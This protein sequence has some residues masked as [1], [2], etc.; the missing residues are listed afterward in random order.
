MQKPLCTDTAARNRSA[1]RR[2]PA[3]PQPPAVDQAVLDALPAHVAVLDQSGTIVAVNRAWRE[4]SRSGMADESETCEG[5]NYPAVCEAVQGTERT[6]AVT[7]AHSLRKTL[8]GELNGFEW[9]YR[10]N[11]CDDE[12]WFLLRAT[13]I[14][15]GDRRRVVVEHEDITRFRKLE[16]ELRSTAEHHRLL[17]EN[18]KDV[19][20]VLDT[21][22]GYFRYVSPSITGL[23]GYTVAETLSQ[24]VDAVMMPDARAGLKAALSQRVAAFHD[25]TE[26]PG[27]YYTDIVEQPRK[28]GS[29]VW[30]EAVSRLRL[31]GE[32]GHV[33]LHGVTRDIT[34]RRAAEAALRESAQFL[35]QGEEIAGIGGW[36]ASPK[37]DHLYWTEGVYRIIEAPRDYR[38]GLDEG[39]KFYTPEYIPVLKQ[40]LHETLEHGTPFK[41]EAEIVTATGRHVWGEVRGLARLDELGERYV[42]GT[43]LDITDR[44]RDEDHRLR[45]AAAIEQATESVV[46]TDAAGKILYVNP[47]FEAT[48]GWRQDEILGSGLSFL[49]SGRHDG[50]FFDHVWATVRG[51]QS[52]RG[53]ITSRRRNGTLYTED[54]AISPVRNRKG[55]VTSFAFVT[56]DITEELAREAHLQQAQKIESGG[57][58]AGGVA[59]DLNNLLS[60]ILGY[61]ELLLDEI[62]TGDSRREFVEEIHYAGLRARN[63]VRQLLAFGRKQTL[64]VKGLDLNSVITHFRKLLRRTIRE[65]IELETHLSASIAPILADVGQIEQVIMN[66]VINAQDAIP[67]AGR[68]VLTTSDAVVD[69]EFAA[70]HQGIKPGRFVLLRISDTG[71]GMDA[72]TLRMIFEPFFTTKEA[73][74]GTGLG[75]ATVYGIVKQHGGSI[76]VD[77]EPGRGTT[78]SIYLP[79]GQ[80]AAATSDTGARR[81]TVRR[82][83][84]TVLVAEDDDR[85]RNLVVTVLTRNGYKVLAA[86]GREEALQR[87]S[88]CGGAIDLLLTDVVMPGGSGRQLHS[89]LVALCPQVKA[90]YMS[91]Y[92]DNEIGMHGILDAGIA[93]LQ[94]PFSVQGLSGKV[95]E[96][97]DN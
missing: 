77:S 79:E 15:D 51:G 83:N 9:E 62:T 3:A 70:G 95:R 84:E 94:K 37:T 16:S 61:C 14:P 96:V 66:L 90:L 20:W 8:S 48:S 10:C 5:T 78:F 69:D 4:F 24:P 87:L 33:E 86:S 73:G 88:E 31:N 56:R 28:D 11:Y 91:G 42:I 49:S 39:L 45:L 19:V 64:D 89:D 67:G 57:R 97:L 58:L 6:E 34:E 93:F 54:V 80:P 71:H 30:T 50:A 36:I 59:H 23:R 12:R 76:Y 68:I 21:E 26:P 27:R 22:T 7:V 75:L 38:P 32:T 44:K 18:M 53:Q 41:V 52:W 82:G 13:A 17:T 25:G 92:A 55:E 72:E 85:V 46:I 65:N 63:L 35:R 2:K 47:A 1:G 29:T 74:K 60:P 43:L 81:R 40:A